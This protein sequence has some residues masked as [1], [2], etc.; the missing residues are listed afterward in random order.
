MITLLIFTSILCLIFA[1]AIVNCINF[2]CKR[3]MYVSIDDPINEVDDGNDDI[4]PIV[5]IQN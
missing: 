5:E 2:A 3:C 4:E 1:F